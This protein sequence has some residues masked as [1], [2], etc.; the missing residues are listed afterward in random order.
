M[1]ALLGGGE[2]FLIAEHDAEKGEPWD[3]PPHDDE[4]YG[5][6]RGR[7][8]VQSVPRARSKRPRRR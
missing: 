5:E 4:A 1:V 8:A 3:V 2:R 6:R 7:A